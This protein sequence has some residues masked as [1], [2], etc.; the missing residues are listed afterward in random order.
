M[1]LKEKIIDLLSKSEPMRSGEIAETLGAD[2]KELEKV[3]KQLKA[4][5]EIISPK[6]CFYSVKNS[7]I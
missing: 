2:K 4:S 7:N 5:E 3:I 1:D 6:R